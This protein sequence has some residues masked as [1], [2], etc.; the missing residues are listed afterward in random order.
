MRDR[1]TRAKAGSTFDVGDLRRRLILHLSAVILTA[2]AL[3]AGL[4]AALTAHVADHEAFERRNAEVALTN[5]A[6]AFEEYTVRFIEQIDE[7]ALLLRQ[8]WI[9]DR[10]NF[11]GAQEVLAPILSR[12]LVFQVAVIGADGRLDYSNLQ[13]SSERI[14]LSDREHFRA[15]LEN[16]RD[17]LFISRPV[18]GR[19]SN[20]WTIQFT[21]KILDAQGAFAGVIVISI[22]PALFGNFL[23]GVDLGGRG[24]ASIVRH[25]GWIVS[26]T[27][28]GRFDTSATEVKLADRPFLTA[29][30][31]VTSGL[32]EANSAVDGVLRIG[33]WRRI[34]PRGLIVVVLMDYTLVSGKS[35]ALRDELRLVQAVG[36]GVILIAAALLGGG[37][38]RDQRRLRRLVASS[39]TLHA[40]SA[41]DA[42]TGI[43]NR[44]RFTEAAEVE[45]KRAQRRGSGWALVMFDLD[46]F[47]VV[48]DTHGH[49]AGDRVLERIGAIVRGALRATDVPARIG[50]EEFGLVLPDTDIA[51]GCAVAEK[52]RAQIAAAEIAIG[53]G[54]TLRI[55]ASFGVTAT[56]TMPLEECY[57]AADQALYASKT[58]GRDR[59]T[60][61]PPH[62]EPDRA[63]DAD[64]QAILRVA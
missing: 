3:M 19:V 23:E 39:E 15:H 29:D 41:T 30:P 54:R 8:A 57:K 2:A 24:I 5:V 34:A 31:T 33:A 53:G 17:F 49:D 27:K 36:T 10:R 13:R 62:P 61:L 11:Q 14:D 59:V 26:R 35:A 32:F 7:A 58:G 22:D 63:Q 56:T 44:R 1:S 21:R 45:V 16:P 9:R 60:A 43:G 18:L 6:H 38:V 52:L 42:L 28:D 20:Q 50:G 25:D 51:G 55:T 40:L 48:N 47:K 46:H 4:H 12:N 37:V 64:P